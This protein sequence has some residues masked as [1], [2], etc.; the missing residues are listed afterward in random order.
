MVRGHLAE[1][2]TIERRS[3][4]TPWSEAA[5]LHEIERNPF[6]HPWVARTS[7]GSVVGYLCLWIIY[8]ELRINNVAVSPEW[9]RQG[10]GERLILF[11]MAAGEAAG[12]RDAILEVRPSNEAAQALY[13]KLGFTDLCTRPRYYSDNGEDALVMRRHLRPQMRLKGA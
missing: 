9:R 10:L 4:P 8:E 11:A 13:R 1:V 7:G 12:C 6:A 3:F 5:F 2:V